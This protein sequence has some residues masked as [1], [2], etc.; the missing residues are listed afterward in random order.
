MRGKNGSVTVM[1]T[2]V[3]VLIL[4]MVGTCVET[5]RYTACAGQGT[6]VLRVG[7]DA[8]LTEYSRPLYDHYGLFFLEDN[9]EP[10]EHVM[11]GYVHDCLQNK[12]GYMDFVKGE[13]TA[14][15]VK[16]KTLVGDKKAEPLM[17]EIT[18]YM[19]RFVAGEELQKLMKK[20]GKFSEAE[21]EASQIEENVEEERE[22]KKLDDR[23][24][25]LMYLVDGVRISDSGKVSVTTWFAKKYATK[26]KFEGVDFG[27]QEATI[28]KGMK[29]KIN[30][31]P[32]NWKDTGQSF[33]DGIRKVKEKTK[34]AIEEGKR[35]K[36]DYMK[37]KHSDMAER[38]IN[39]IPSLNGNLR[40]L[41]ETEGL[42]TDHSVNNKE[43]K[44]RLKA[45]WKDYDTESL[46]IDYSGV[47]QAGGDGAS[48]LDA[49][50]D[51]IGGGLLSLVCE[52]PDKLSKKGIKQEDRYA[53][54]YKQESKQGKNYGERM[55]H[56]ARDEEVE[57]SGTMGDVAAYGLDEFML[58]SYITKMF[59][60]YT[61]KL[62]QY[63]KDTNGKGENKGDNKSGNIAGRD[64]W[65]GGK[66][67]GTTGGD[68]NAS[69]KK[70]WKHALSYGWEYAVAGEKS[71]KDN[72]ESVLSRIMILRTVTNFLAIL[73]DGSKRA[74]A[75][76][77]AVAV[78]GFTGLVFL[79]RFTQTLIM[80]V[81]A[82]VESMTDVAA[83]LMERDVP[84]VKQSKQ[85][86]TTFPE[87]F[88]I[89]NSAITTRAKKYAKA[90]KTSFGYREYIWLFLAMTPAHT[91]RYR[92][93]D[94]IENDMKKNGYKSFSMGKSVFDLTVEG[95]FRYPSKF[96]HLP[97]ISDILNRDVSGYEYLCRIRAGYL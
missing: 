65:S 78:V 97:M 10:L 73:A 49:L 83:L 1:L 27:I 2:L 63:K 74:E 68:N 55:D 91:R 96:F 21:D 17:K 87:V 41:E 18:T 51:A 32:S 79:I 43:K 46:S 93:M 34:E 6:E 89:T 26:K 39:G 88:L 66:I 80:I 58:D 59:P 4:A 19:E 60:S 76:A 71:D 57:L 14:L 42:L 30:K 16:K 20:I 8:L 81:W 13:L 61:Q 84:I 48:P 82:M 47:D 12:P 77:A 56:L 69:G 15:S 23:V 22:D 40:V 35:L 94:M 5:A 54:Y 95:G 3:G 70:E 31:T 33:L 38:V 53:K 36:N 44:K 85:I 92:V 72:L 62:K 50:G 64:T 37:A 52:K 75:F 25:R 86:K 7:A 28:W 29:P 9:G 24:V 67:G 11:A 90:K 45:L